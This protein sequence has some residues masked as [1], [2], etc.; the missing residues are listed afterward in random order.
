MFPGSL[1]LERL[2]MDAIYQFVA[3]ILFVFL[4]FEFCFQFSSMSLFCDNFSLA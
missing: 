3:N 1:N 4:G 2:W